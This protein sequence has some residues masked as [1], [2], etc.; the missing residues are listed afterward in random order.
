M[1]INYC[2]PLSIL[3]YLTA[4]RENSVVKISIAN[5]H[6]Q[7]IDSCINSADVPLPKLFTHKKAENIGNLNMLDIQTH[8]VGIVILKV[9]K[10][11]LIKYIFYRT[12]SVRPK[13]SAGPA[14]S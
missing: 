10:K 8:M 9:K 6:R 5:E 14:L 12:L 7:S 13:Q 1:F 4:L 2:C 11:R 3:R